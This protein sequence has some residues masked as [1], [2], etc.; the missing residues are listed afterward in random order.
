VLQQKT[1][2]AGGLGGRTSRS[3]AAPAIPFYLRRQFLPSH[4]QAVFTRAARARL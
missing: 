1:Q 2:H 4:R 3:E